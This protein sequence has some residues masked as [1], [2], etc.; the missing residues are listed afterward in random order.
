LRRVTLDLTGTIPTADDTRA[1]LNDNS[2]DKRA[3]L[4]DRLLAS[5]EHARHLAAVST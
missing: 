2:A 1:F 4:I 3:K 5:P